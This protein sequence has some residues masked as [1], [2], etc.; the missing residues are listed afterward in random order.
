MNRFILANTEQL[1]EKIKTMSERIRQ[2]EEALETLQAKVSAT[3]HPLLRQELLS[4]KKSPELFG[5]DQRVMVPEGQEPHQQRHDEQ[6]RASSSTSSR[7]A[8]EVSIINID[9]FHSD[10]V[11]LV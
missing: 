1:H 3:E 11:L 10:L 9:C 8:D 7:D 2:L 6:P 5:I 4:I